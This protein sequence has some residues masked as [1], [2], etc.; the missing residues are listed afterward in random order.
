MLVV[1]SIARGGIFGN[2][3]RKNLLPTL[4]FQSDKGLAEYVE[5][6]TGPYCL[7]SR[8]FSQGPERVERTGLMSSPPRRVK[9]ALTSSS[10]EWQCPL[11][12]A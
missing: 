12:S 6:R 8:R 5:A 7:G 10:R 11:M 2:A 1:P 3:G 9:R 4:I